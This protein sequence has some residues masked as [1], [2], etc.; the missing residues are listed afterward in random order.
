MACGRDAAELVRAT[1][2]EGS[3]KSHRQT[4]LGQGLSRVSGELG[5]EAQAWQ[6]SY[7][8]KGRGSNQGQT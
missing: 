3:M 4:T 1:V 7:S 6:Q 5:S 2:D 8:Q